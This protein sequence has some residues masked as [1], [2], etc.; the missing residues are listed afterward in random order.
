MLAGMFG[1]KSV[2]NYSGVFLHLTIVLS[3]F[4]TSIWLLTE[5]TNPKSKKVYGIDTDWFLKFA[6]IFQK[7]RTIFENMDLQSSADEVQGKFSIKRECDFCNNQ[8]KKK[9]QAIQVCLRHGTDENFRREYDGL[10]EAM[11]YFNRDEGLLITKK[12][13]RCVSKRW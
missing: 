13:N 1:I 3:R 2:S 7:H 4:H 9:H 6:V 12:R 8:K 5:S 11:N 10:P